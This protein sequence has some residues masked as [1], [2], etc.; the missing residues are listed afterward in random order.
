[1]AVS[2][3]VILNLVQS[4]V[5]NSATQVEKG[6]SK[7]GQDAGQGF[8]KSFSE[9]IAKSPEMQRAFDKAADAAGKLRVEEQRL[10]DIQEKGSATRAQLISQSERVEKAHRD[11]ARSARD[12][13][14]AYER[15]GVKAGNS[16][17]II[18]RRTSN[19]LGT[20]S[21]LTAG[22]RLGGI[23]SSLSTISG[24]ATEAG[25]ALG[26]IG[27]SAVA[28]GIVA[29]GAV[30]ALG[31]AAVV[32]TKNLYDMGAQWDQVFDNI[33]IKTGATGSQLEAL[34]NS[35]MNIAGNVPD[36]IGRIG[37][38]VAQTSRALHVTG[39]D[40]EFVSTNIANLGRLTGEDINIRQL[41]QAFRMFHVESKDMVPTL[42]SLLQASQNTGIGI[43]ELVQSA[44]KGG[45]QLK[46]FGFNF[47]QATSLITSLEEIGVDADSIMA[48]LTKSLA[49]I[50]KEGKNPV[51][52]LEDTVRQV[53]ELIAVGK[54]PEAQNLVNNLFGGRGGLK[55]FE[56]IKNN[57]LDVE[58]LN[59]SL[60]GTGNTIQGL[61]DDTDDFAQHWKEF[62][63]SASVFLEPVTK[64]VYDLVDGALVD[65]TDFM[66]GGFDRGKV[67]AENYA[68]A[69]RKAKTFADELGDSLSKVKAQ[70]QDVVINVEDNTPDVQAKLD[71]LG[72]HL[73]QMGNDPTHLK[74]VPDTPEAEEKLEA[75]RR[76]QE[77]LPLTIP[78]GINYE[79][80]VKFTPEW[81]QKY[82]RGEPLPYMSVPLNFIPGGAPFNYPTA[83]FS[84]GGPGPNANLPAP[85]PA[86]SSAPVAGDFTSLFPT[87][88]GGG[89]AGRTD[90]GLLWGPGT[91]TS[92]SILGVDPVTGMPTARVSNGEGVVKAS[93]MQRPGVA[94]L[95]AGL[96]SYATGYPGV[97]D[98][99]GW[100]AQIASQFGLQLTSGRRNEPGSYHNLG[101]AGDFSNGS[102][103][104]PQ[105]RAF[106]EYMSRNFGS[107]IS[108][109]IYSEPGFSGL[110]G[111][112]KNV[113]GSGYY[114]PKTLSEHQNHVH[115]AI[116]PGALA[117][118]SA[119]LASQNGPQY[120]D[121]KRVREAEQKVQDADAKVKIAEQRLAEA[122]ADIKES[123]RLRL[124]DDLRKARR[125][126]DDA[127]ADL[128]Q[129]KQGRLVSGGV[130]SR[131]S[132]MSGPVGAPLA[133]DFG[134][135]EGLP[136][137]A[138][139]ATTFLANLAFAPMTG[140]LSA[141]SA[142]SPYQGGYGLFGMLGAQNMS[143]GLSPL[144]LSMPSPG[145]TGGGASAM[146]PAP[147]GGGVGDTLHLGS[148]APP[149]PGAPA[150]TPSVSL[151]PTANPSG[152]FQ[153]L[154]GLPMQ[155]ITSAIAAGS[156]AVDAMAPGAGAV[157]GQAA[158]IGVQL[159]NRTAAYAGQ[160]AGI[161]VGGLLETLLPH[162]SPLADPGKSWI[163]R[164]AAGFAGARPALPNSAGQGAGQPAPPQTPEEAAKLAQQNGGGPGNGPMVN[165]ENLNNYTPDGGQQIANQIGRL[166]MSTYAS[167]GPR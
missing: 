24:A 121:P 10:K 147:L 6:L 154:G 152:G 120:A 61:A 49:Q 54:D 77:N 132:S 128:Q 113:T 146:G 133:E 156:L 112:G 72:Y 74:L 62:S 150:G 73:E 64:A 163:G 87:R 144:G 119:M 95:I 122:K 166:Q 115:I 116:M 29:A 83:P 50:A 143:Q 85:P 34:Q 82:L 145:F 158:Q 16:L 19:L 109:L 84:P 151:A 58:T 40:L 44:V 56:A 33:Q 25:A 43:N 123:E 28:T 35:T 17:D 80:G 3:D 100:V 155:G 101:E 65:L 30:G 86:A 46:E 94:K 124:E 96:N 51:T 127:R 81:F 32:V 159:A 165:V 98:E 38:V 139:F 148:G 69:I 99:I 5:K 41:G 140:A 162:D 45:Y 20:F 136:G 135:S 157:A 8:A 164:V 91:A 76:K 126:S 52:V 68:N 111:N 167:G 26:S 108:E 93:A 21:S 92:D 1:M 39:S 42:D 149:G 89:I 63:N 117:P 97:T 23:T 4:S 134:L 161:G 79:A 59:K 88:A 12:A 67:A 142:A 55:I 14:E 71:S 22:T 106:A 2:L 53:K 125:D 153:G 103:N 47:G 36:D 15:Y 90:A 104:T 7:A 160:A 131:G 118:A 75:F 102:G 37:D 110:I 141:V 137:L 105:M 13:A 66:T 27:S 138:K 70:G 31:A 129:V 60:Q 78:L 114:S 107:M 11:V 18:N 9:S 130:S 48:P 57:A